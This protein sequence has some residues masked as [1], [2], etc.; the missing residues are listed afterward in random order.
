MKKIFLVLVSAGFLVLLNNQLVRAEDKPVEPTVKIEASEPI[1]IGN[2]I[3]PV[4]GEKI[5]EKLKSTYEYEG[6]IYNFCCA[7][8]IDEFKKD[9]EKYIKK[10]EE[11]LQAES[12][13]KEVE[14]KMQI[15]SEV[16]SAGDQDVHRGLH[17][18][19]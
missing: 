4:S 9:P 12:K 8:C 11:E 14:H 10:V 13:A 6:E 16:E 18:Q 3:C 1:N 15:E 19:H 5:D 7:M 2:K 17:H